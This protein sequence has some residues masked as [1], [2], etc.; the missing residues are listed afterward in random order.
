MSA[1]QKHMNVSVVTCLLPLNYSRD[2]ED[3]RSHDKVLW[4]YSV[5]MYHSPSAW[6]LSLGNT[7]FPFTTRSYI[8]LSGNLSLLGLVSTL[9]PGLARHHAAPGHAF[10]QLLNL[11][12]AVHKLV[13]LELESR[14]FDQLNEG[15]EETPG[16]RSVDNQPFEQHP[17]KKIVWT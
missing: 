15:D 14:I 7:Y 4:S 11:R 10:K 2:V 16:V 8:L 12:G 1:R 6:G 13:R 3:W 5:N 9:L 17:G